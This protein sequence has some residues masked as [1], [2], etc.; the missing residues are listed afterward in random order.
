VRIS[1]AGCKPLPAVKDFARQ[2]ADNASYFLKTNNQPIRVKVRISVQ[3]KDRYD[4][5]YE[6]SKG[7]V[8]EQEF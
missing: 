6:P 8:D 7:V 1:F 2:A 5:D 3:G 4:L